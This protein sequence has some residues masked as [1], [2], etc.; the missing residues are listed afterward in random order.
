MADEHPIHNAAGVGRFSSEDEKAQEI[1][2]EH[3]NTAKSEDA[4]HV[5]VAEFTKEEEEA[6]IRKLDW[7]L[8]P[9]IFVLYS[10]SVLDRSNL[11]NAKIAGMQTDINLGGN[12]YNWL[13]TIFYISCEQ[14]RTKNLHLLT[15]YKT[16]F[17]SGHRWDGRSFHLTS[18]LPLRSFAGE[19]YRLFKLQQLAG[20]D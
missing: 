10:L 5:P 8:M 6:V 16:F 2:V 3:V 1:D 7:H 19:L 11:G 13:G 14:L 4:A 15:E 17:S 20:R 12:R 18:G 9:L